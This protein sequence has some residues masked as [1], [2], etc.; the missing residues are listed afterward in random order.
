[1]K[2]AW[3]REHVNKERVIW[4][5]GRVPVSLATAFILAGIVSRHYKQELR[6]DMIE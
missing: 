5:R 1:M 3:S 2:G 6:S 4:G